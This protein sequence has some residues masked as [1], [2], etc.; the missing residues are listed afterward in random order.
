MKTSLKGL[1]GVLMVVT[2]LACGGATFAKQKTISF[3]YFGNVDEMPI[4]QEMIKGF[5][6]RHPEINVKF[7]PVPATTWGEYFDKMATMIAGGVTPDVVRVAIEGTQL[8]ADK[9]LALPL[10]SYIERDKAELQEF[11]D[12]VHPKLLEVF[13]YKGH[14]YEFV[15]EWNNMVIYYNTKLFEENGIKR[16][17]DN[18]DKD[19]FLEIAQKL[20][21]DKDG[22]GTPEQ[23][24]YATANEYFWGA[25]PWIFNFGSSLLSDDWSKSNANDPKFIA[26]ITWIQ[27]L[28]WKYKVAPPPAVIDF[29]PFFATGK[30]A[31]CGWG[32]W[33]VCSFN[34]MNFFDYDIM[35]WPKVE[36]QATEFGVGGFP[37]MKGTKYPDEAWKLI[38]YLTSKESMAYTTGRGIS[39]P[40]RRSLAY[41]PEVMG[42]YPKH[43]RIFYDS[44][45]QGKPVPSPPEYN[46]A[47]DI[48]LRYLS[49][50]NANEITPEEAAAGT[51]R[52]ISAVLARRGK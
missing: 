49:A 33:P 7:I 16:P 47:Q 51:H 36:T 10:D 4:L 35:Y 40:G 20:T 43:S 25:M 17:P 41:D 1:V 3:V 27:D 32:R 50:M 2:L 48:W 8:F 12:D 45:E 31:M 24:G 26:A 11:F 38:K 37:I 46:E 13:R 19:M 28:I 6:N 52:E 9:G 21:V 44:L 14:V 29:F 34:N 39:I 30:I 15:Y 18:W 42:E 23:Y 22:D 5:S